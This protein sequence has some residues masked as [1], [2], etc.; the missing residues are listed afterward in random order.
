[1][2]FVLNEDQR[3]RTAIRSGASRFQPL[4]LIRLDV[5]G[6]LRAMKNLLSIFCVIRLNKQIKRS[7][8]TRDRRKHCPSTSIC[9]RFVHARETSKLNPVFHWNL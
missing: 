6:L 9:T 1:L 3:R 8:A 5:I 2:G 4:A 7:Q